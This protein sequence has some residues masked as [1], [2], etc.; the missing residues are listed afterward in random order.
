MIAN[1]YP[2]LAQKVSRLL[3][4]AF[5]RF[6]LPIVEK[7][8]VK[9]TN[10]ILLPRSTKSSRNA[11]TTFAIF[12]SFALYSYFTIYFYFDS[13]IWQLIGAGFVFWLAGIGLL[14]AKRSVDFD[15]DRGIV[16]TRTR[17][18]GQSSEEEALVNQFTKVVITKEERQYRNP[19][20]QRLQTKSV[21][22]VR[23]RGTTGGTFDVATHGNVSNSR[24]TAERVSRCLNLPVEDSSS[25]P[26]E[27][28]D[29]AQSIEL[30]Q[31]KL[32]REGKVLK[33]PAL[34]A[35][36]K[37]HLEA[38]HSKATITVPPQTRVLIVPTVMGL[39]LGMFL[40]SEFLVIFS[41]FFYFGTIMIIPIAFAV[42]SHVRRV[43]QPHF[44]TM[45]KEAITLTLGQNPGEVIASVPTA[46]LNELSLFGQWLQ[47][48]SD[49]AFITI[50]LG[51]RKEAEW[52]KQVVEYKLLDMAKS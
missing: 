42:I 12:A 27:V 1:T 43:I 11:L 13:V 45:D 30:I 9:D 8:F 6:F 51:S 34:P 14:S 5:Q 26:L 40:W 49:R 50:E 18:F 19:Q 32:L 23:L 28:R 16:R 33:E 41:G 38:G 7:I 29:P 48:S 39:I 35:G 47:G 4:V 10:I 52:L 22:P 2:F 15:P 37:L 17:T 24:N 25:G 21:Y 36:S 20:D 31:E 44:I 46:E 3:Y